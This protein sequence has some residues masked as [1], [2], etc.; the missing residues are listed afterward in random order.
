VHCPACGRAVPLAAGERVGFRAGCDGCGADLHA[1]RACRHFDAH[2]YNECRERSAERVLD[3]ERGNLCEHF[4]PGPGD[5]VEGN[6]AATDR[7]LA[8]ADLA[9]LFER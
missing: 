7:E 8:A 9:R 3:K 1:C 2:A 4:V 6:T 5:R